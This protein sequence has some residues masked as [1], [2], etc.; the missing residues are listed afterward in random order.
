MIDAG[1]QRVCG[2]RAYGVCLWVCS[3]ASVRAGKMLAELRVRVSALQC[4]RACVLLDGAA[5]CRA[6]FGFFRGESL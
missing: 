1:R 6:A 4:L 3:E 5:G 2:L